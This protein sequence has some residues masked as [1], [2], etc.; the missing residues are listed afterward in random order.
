MIL[1]PESDISSDGVVAEKLRQEIAH[2][3]FDHVG[4]LTVS[5]D[6]TA[7]APDEDIDTLLKR[8]DDAF[9]KGKENGRNR[10]ELL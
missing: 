10:I 2:F 8:V 6:V 4:S 7:F 3:S 1:M 5:F 9:Y